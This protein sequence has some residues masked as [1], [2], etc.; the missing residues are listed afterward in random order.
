MVLS[1]SAA[2]FCASIDIMRLVV[3]LYI[4]HATYPVVWIYRT[5]SRVPFS[6]ILPLPAAM[7][8]P[9]GLPKP[10]SRYRE[11]KQVRLCPTSACSILIGNR[12]L[13]R[14]IKWLSDSHLLFDN[15]FSEMFC[16]FCVSYIR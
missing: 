7:V 12:R 5:L 2:L 1:V 4:C 15:I 9:G 10:P 6:F 13:P 3:G 8:T 14:V 11:A 16:Y